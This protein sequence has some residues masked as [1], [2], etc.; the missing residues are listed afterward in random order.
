MRTAAAVVLCLS[1]GAAAGAQS[2]TEPKSGVAFPWK[3]DGMSLLGA[4]LRVKKV[5][6]VKA[7][8]YAIGLYV[9]DDALAGPLAAH[10]GHVGTPAFYKDLVWGDFGKQVV[11][12]FTR[13]LG[14]ARIQ[15]AMREAL[16]G[17]DAKPL[18][19]FVGYFPEVK[20]GQEC[21]LRWGPGGSL[22]STMAGAARPPLADK[23]FAARV[24]GLYLGETP[25]QD[26]FK[27]DLVSRAPELLKP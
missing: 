22:E 3:R 26:D 18:D 17:A 23:A 5:A 14:Q 4:G 20:E 15:E 21:V 11:L 9:A 2:L 6:F 12:H 24:F 1:L 25:L 7:K 10:R 13:S 27:T 8:V 19:T 16:A